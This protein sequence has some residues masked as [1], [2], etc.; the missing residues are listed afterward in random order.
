M[1]A[2]TIVIKRRKLTPRM[3]GCSGSQV[4]TDPDEIGR[5]TRAR[6]CKPL[7]NVGFASLFAVM[8]P[9]RSGPRIDIRFRPLRAPLQMPGRHFELLGSGHSLGVQ[10]PDAAEAAA[11]RS[12]ACLPRGCQSATGPAADRRCNPLIGLMLVG[13][14]F[15]AALLVEIGGAQVRRRFAEGR[16][17]FKPFHKLQKQPIG[18]RR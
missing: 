18:S 4:G 1:S 5:L 6:T 16:P 9:V 2:S 17:T 11:C 13:S 15:G 14:G 3:Y 10:G 7:C 12:A 8:R